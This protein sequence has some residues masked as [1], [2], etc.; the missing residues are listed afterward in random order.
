[1]V[2]RSYIKNE[3]KNMNETQLTKGLDALKENPE[4]WQTILG[5]KDGTTDAYMVV[6]EINNELA[7]RKKNDT[8]PP[9]PEQTIKTTKKRSD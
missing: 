1:M 3:V 6:G 8:N 7:R 5:K 2:S 4:F 9:P